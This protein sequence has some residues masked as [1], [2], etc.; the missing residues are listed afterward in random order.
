MSFIGTY[1]HE[2]DFSGRD[3]AKILYGKWQCIWSHV[4][5]C[6]HVVFDRIAFHVSMLGW[7]LQILLTSKIKYTHL[8]WSFMLLDIADLLAPVFGTIF[9][10]MVF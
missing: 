6:E 7:K 9:V 1:S 5:H 4:L 2:H 10:M 3:V 8:G